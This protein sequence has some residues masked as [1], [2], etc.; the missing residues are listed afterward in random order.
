[1]AT[2]QCHATY[3]SYH[4]GEILSRVFSLETHPGIKMVWFDTNI[5]P[6]PFCHGQDCVT[7]P[8]E[9]WACVLRATHVRLMVI[10]GAKMKNT[11]ITKRTRKLK[12][13]IVGRSNERVM[14]I[15]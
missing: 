6:S 7:L 4:D 9:L 11:L 12:W 5:K 3:T 15:M 8:L 14:V 1:M 10:V 13:Q 2:D